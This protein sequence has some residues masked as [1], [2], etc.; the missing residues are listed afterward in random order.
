MKSVA[1]L[2][3]CFLLVLCPCYGHSGQEH[4]RDMKIVFNGYGGAEFDELARKVNATI[5]TEL[6]EAFRK[7]IGPLPGNHRILGHGWTMNDAIPHE[8]L[9]KLET[10]YPGK[11]KEIVAIWRTTV[12]NLCAYAQRVTGLPPN[13][14]AALVAIMYDIHLLGD[15]EPGNKL[16]DNVLSPHD[17]V[18]NLKKNFKILFR[19]HPVIA[20][21]ICNCLQRVLSSAKGGVQNVARALMTALQRLDIGGKLRVA[22]QNTLKLPFSKQAV[23][24]AEHYKVRRDVRNLAGKKAKLT[25]LRSPRSAAKVV[26]KSARRWITPALITESG[27]ILVPT[28]VGFGVFCF[29]AGEAVFAFYR[30]SILKEEF[31]RRM[32]D[33]VIKGVSCGAAHAVLLCITPVPGGL[34]VTVVGIAA[35]EVTDCVIGIFRRRAAAKM[36][37]A[38]DLQMFGL[39]VNSIFSVETGSVFEVEGKSVLDIPPNT[40]FEPDEDSL[41]EVPAA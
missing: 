26:E 11:K 12:K 5:D 7:Q 16:L 40:I 33:S 4:L 9:D 18:K 1:Y 19:N 15:L 35:Y 41:F 39:E 31:E 10:R 36:L 8:V 34:L 13:Q 32:V 3:F 30:G 22:W 6:P 14:A 25:P 17:I 27:A 28:Q 24:M 20:N 37:T 21:Q 29:D 23:H 2:L 38:E